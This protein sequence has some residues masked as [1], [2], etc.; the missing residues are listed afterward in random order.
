MV[1]RRPEAGRFSAARCSNEHRRLSGGESV[2]VVR[3][4]RRAR[5][6]DFQRDRP[7]AQSTDVGARTS[8]TTRAADH[9]DGYKL[10]AMCTIDVRSGGGGSRKRSTHSR[11]RASSPPAPTQFASLID[12][13]ERAAP[14]ARRGGNAHRPVPID[15]RGAGASCGK[16]LLNLDARAAQNRFDV[17]IAPY[18]QSSVVVTE[19]EGLV[20]V[21]LATSEPSAMFTQARISTDV[22]PVRFTVMNRA[23]RSVARSSP[24][25][26]RLLRDIRGLRLPHRAPQ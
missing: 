17:A 6:R 13:F 22:S 10:G 21:G 11:R 25:A 12:D 2:T 20:A 3:L 14:L 8:A 7:E 19:W 5:T 23:R 18:V 9:A 15:L 4:G 26:V 16:L 24:W 1:Q